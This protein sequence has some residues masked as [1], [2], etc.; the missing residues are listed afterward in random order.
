MKSVDHM[1]EN[2]EMMKKYQPNSGMLREVQQQYSNMASGGDGG[3]AHY[4]GKPIKWD[5]DG[6]PIAW[7]S[8]REHNYP[9]HSDEFFQEVCDRMDWKY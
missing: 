6:E 8:I 1:V 9:A 3:M 5:L 4:V 2:Y 7:K